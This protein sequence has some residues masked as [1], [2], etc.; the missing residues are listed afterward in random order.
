MPYI[1]EKF[2]PRFTGVIGSGPN[3]QHW[4]LGRRWLGPTNAVGHKTGPATVWRKAMHG[5]HA[6]HP[7]AM[8]DGPFV[9]VPINPKKPAGPVG[10]VPRS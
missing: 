8:N 2:Q 9:H 7:I 6:G 5:E 3:A 10:L 1:D 4:Y